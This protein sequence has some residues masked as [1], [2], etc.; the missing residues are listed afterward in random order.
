MNR[1]APAGARR[2]A[3]GLVPGLVLAGSG[4]SNAPTIPSPGSMTLYNTVVSE[5][6]T[7]TSPGA[8]AAIRSAAGVSYVSLAPGSY[9][10]GVRVTILN[11]ANGNQGSV[12]MARGGWDPVAI[13]A[14][15]GDTLRI[16]VTTTLNTTIEFAYVVPPMRRPTILRTEPPVSKRDVPLNSV[17]VVVFSEPIDPVSVTS[18]RVQLLHNGQPVG[19][20]F[21]ISADGLRMTVRP[22]EA[23]TVN[24][25]YVLSVSPE[26]EDLAGD[27]LDRG[28][29]VEFNTVASFPSGELA[30]VRG[31]DIITSA[32]DGSN[33]GTLVQDGTRPSWSPDGTRL[34][35]TRP[36]G[37]SLA[38]WQL[39]I[40]GSDGADIR[41]ATGPSGEEIQGGL[42]IS[43]PSW[44]PDGEAIAFS[45]FI[46]SCPGGE[47]GQFGGYYTPLMLLHT[48]TMQVDT[49]PTPTGVYSASWS[50]DGR[51]IALAIFGPGA[52]G[53][54]RLG[55]V[56]ADGT[57]FEIVAERF[58]S[59]LVNDVAWSP[60]GASFALRLTDENACPWYCDTAIGIV[61]T[62]GTQLRILDRV[63]NTDQQYFWTRPE[64][65]PDGRYLAYTVTNGGSCYL[66]DLGCND[67]GVVEVSSGRVSRLL[68]NGAY[69]SWRPS[70]IGSIRR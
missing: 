52:M 56:N 7:P 4:C 21:E 57:G 17:I 47:C 53:S 5:P 29:Q 58:G 16:M 68:A 1:Q 34:A 45:A 43:G 65:S 46:Y 26:I 64:W 9:P 50:P 20:D 49:L 18:Q 31:M 60:D 37:N 51:K 28:V 39:C 70:A 14:D 27:P 6:Q 62:D 55:T 54:G 69:P 10:N 63:R 38:S 13:A 44:S 40:A 35:F 66:H 3:L 59:Y 32:T 23:L 33:P 11:P 24:T 22:R 15:P 61:N 30:F 42:I 12:E 67:L 41:C 36:T 19:T 8:S 25:G 48:A 2:L